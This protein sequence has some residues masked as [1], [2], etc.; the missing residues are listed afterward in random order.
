MIDQKIFNTADW[1]VA[2]TVK[3]V[4]VQ[5]TVTE[6]VEEYELVDDIYYGTTT[7]GPKVVGQRP[8]GMRGAAFIPV[9]AP[10]NATFFS[11]RLS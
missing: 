9:T 1:A 4:T 8:S 7:P 3:P 11:N 5:Q 6:N 2:S 10:A